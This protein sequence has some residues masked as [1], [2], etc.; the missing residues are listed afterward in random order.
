MKVKKVSP[1]APD[2][3]PEM[4]RIGGV[5]LASIA[6]GIRY[7]GCDDLMLA[8]LD[9]DTTVAGVFTRS[10]CPAATVDWCRHA[11]ENNGGRARAVICNTGNANAFTGA[12]RVR[13]HPA[14]RAVS[15]RNT[16]F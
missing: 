11:L 13:R 14:D 9:P 5:R 2:S 3:F 7:S 15:R 1:L 12:R 4:P 6:A 16:E 10:L 8:V